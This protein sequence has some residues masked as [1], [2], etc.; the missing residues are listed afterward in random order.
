MYEIVLDLSDEEM[1]E[2]EA[3]ASS[4]DCTVDQLA[5]AIFKDRLDADLAE[6]TP[7]TALM[8][9]LKAI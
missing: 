9:Q 7:T 6:I 4:Y 8:N 1:Q 5:T 3:L 2:I